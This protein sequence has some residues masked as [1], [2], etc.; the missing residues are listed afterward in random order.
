MARVTVEGLRKTYVRAR[1]P[2]P[3]LAGISL[4][5]PHATCLAI[6]GPSGCG[7]TTLLRVVA[8]LERPDEG[9]VAFD[10]RDVTRD[11]VATR[12]TGFVFASDALFPHRSLFENIAY[13]L[14][15]A[16][17]REP[18]RTR[19]V[20][21]AATRMRVGVSLDARP[22]DCSSG[23]RQRVALARA[24]AAAPQALL[25]DE[26]FARLD[27][28]LRANLRLE[29][30]RVRRER[31]L[32]TLFV[33][34][35]QREA[36]ALGDRVAVMRDGRLEQV[37]TP[38]DLFARPATRFVASFVGAPAMAFVAAD[39]FGDANSPGATLG[40][41]ADAVRVSVAGTLG[42]VVSAVEDFVDDAYAY[43]DTPVGALVARLAADDV[44]PR[45]G[46]RVALAVDVARAH[47]FDGAGRRVERALAR[48]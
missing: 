45:A 26:P 4:D 7:K 36:L 10:G 40:L 33:T 23:E 30:A 14:P 46:E 35:D 44:R 18:A 15:A 16:Q 6:L 24:L 22:R 17:R 42:G 43:V 3:A 31:A 34:H 37:G 1:R 12:R 41:R 2:V 8:G 11:P 19:A 9:R 27:A 29:I 47:A 13:G 5:V 48:V 28:T 25:L 21:D 20:C 39:A 38:D 32:T